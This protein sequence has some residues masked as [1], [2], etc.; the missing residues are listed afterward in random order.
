MVPGR[1]LNAQRRGAVKVRLDVPTARERAD[2]SIHPFPPRRA[3]PAHRRAQCHRPAWRRWLSAKLPA[4]REERGWGVWETPAIW[5]IQCIFRYDRQRQ[6]QA[7]PS[8]PGGRQETGSFAV[9]RFHETFRQLDHWPVAGDQNQAI[10]AVTG[11]PPRPRNPSCQNS[12]LR[13]ND[14][15]EIRGY[16]PLQKPLCQRDV[17]DPNAER[18]TAL[19]WQVKAQRQDDKVLCW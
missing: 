17:S 4:V 12:L 18:E 6:V 16:P 13:T 3:A 19:R 7:L 10:H 11:V 8:R 15:R 1:H 9:V 5:C 14:M 2:P